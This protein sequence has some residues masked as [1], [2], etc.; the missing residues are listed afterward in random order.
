M[1]TEAMTL[2]DACPLE[3]KLWQG[4]IKGLE[5]NYRILEAEGTLNDLVQ[6]F[7]FLD[8]KNQGPEKSRS[9]NHLVTEL[10]IKTKKIWLII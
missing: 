4:R 6:T 3:G 9:I 1:V 10:R 2:K 7:I 8:E 5:K